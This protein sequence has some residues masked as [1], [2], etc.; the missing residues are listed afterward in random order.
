MHT[1]GTEKM[2]LFVFDS[3]AV[4]VVDFNLCAFYVVNSLNTE[5]S[6]DSGIVL[7]QSFIF[8]IFQLQQVLM[9]LYLE[10]KNMVDNIIKFNFESFNYF[11]LYLFES[12]LCVYIF[13]HMGLMVFFL[14]KCIFLDFKKL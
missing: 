8:T 11:I 2:H 6:P 4:D 7:D 3:V 10:L 1:H 5:K 12:I 13:L 14:T 9:E